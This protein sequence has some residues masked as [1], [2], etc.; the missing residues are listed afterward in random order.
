MSGKPHVERVDRGVFWLMCN[1]SVLE[2]EFNFS[3]QKMLFTLNNLVNNQGTIAME[4]HNTL[5][6]Q[7][8]LLVM[9]IDVAWRLT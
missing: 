1:N 4:K 7:K 2:F 9:S 3:V 5:V 6:C 8:G